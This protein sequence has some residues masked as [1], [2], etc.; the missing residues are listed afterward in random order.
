MPERRRYKN[1]PIEEALCEFRFKPSQD[2]DLTIPGKVH[3]ELS[4]EYTSKLQ[5][6]GVADEKRTLN[7]LASAH[8]FH[9][10]GFDRV[11]LFSP[12]GK[13]IVGI[14]HDTISIHMLC[15]Y[16]DPTRSDGGGWDEFQSRISAALGAY[17]KVANPV[18]VRR[19]DIRYINNIETPKGIAD[20]KDYLKCILPDIEGIPFD[21][22]NFVSQVD[23][24]Y[25]NDIRLVLSQGLIRREPSAA[26]LLD[27]DFVWEISESVGQEEA[28]RKASHLRGLERKVFES[29]ITDKS[30]EIFDAN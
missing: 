10:G 9:G 4:E 7:E 12:N 3:S 29:I 28:L 19:V 23:Y 25:G 11:N 2:W 15:P 20:I 30:R 13:R 26:V 6:E 5:K 27:L 21:Q 18:G 8:L 14:G 16:Q 1:P 17:W 24:D 22:N